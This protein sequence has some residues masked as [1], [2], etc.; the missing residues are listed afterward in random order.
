MYG[1]GEGVQWGQSFR[2]FLGNMILIEAATRC[3]RLMLVFHVPAQP[4]YLCQLIVRSPLAIGLFLNEP[5]NSWCTINKIIYYTR[6]IMQIIL[7]FYYFMVLWSCII[8]LINKY[9]LVVDYILWCLN[10][11]SWWWCSYKH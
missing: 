2:T 5:I 11:F 9:F 10:V 7:G 8:L 3:G 4:H 1:Q 6:K